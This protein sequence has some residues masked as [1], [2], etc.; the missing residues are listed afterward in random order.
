MISIITDDELFQ[1]VIKV[2]FNF[3]SR[4]KK[5]LN[6]FV[7]LDQ[8]I[9]RLKFSGSRSEPC[10]PQ[11]S[12]EYREVFHGWPSINRPPLQRRATHLKTPGGSMDTLTEQQQNYVP[13]TSEVI[14]NCHRNL[15]RRPENLRLTGDIELFPEYRSAF[16]A[17]NMNNNSNQFKKVIRPTIP[18][19]IRLPRASDPAKERIE[20]C[21]LGLEGNQDLLPEYKSK[22]VTLPLERSRLMPQGSHLSMKGQFGGVPEYQESFRDFHKYGKNLPIKRSD[23]LKPGG[24]IQDAPEYKERFKEPDWSTFRK[25]PSYKK[26]DNLRPGGEFSKDLP[27]YN[28]SFR[29]YHMPKPEKGK[30]RATY[31]KLNG[32]TDWHPEYR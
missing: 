28:E 18:S 26:S 30:C 2:S 14:H 9:S 13:Y 11:A 6:P 29:D 12:T 31:F 17:I 8:R 23:N 3:N 15:I 1:I 27:E 22:Y 21:H 16:C 5:S 25:V 4:Q 24:G 10:L 20:R 32:D 7:I 19:P